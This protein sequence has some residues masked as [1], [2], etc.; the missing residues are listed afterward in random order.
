MMLSGRP[1]DV[2]MRIEPVDEITFDP[3][4]AMGIRRT[5]WEA[6]ADEAPVRSVRKLSPRPWQTLFIRAF[7]EDESHDGGAEACRSLMAFRNANVRADLR[8][9]GSPEQDHEGACREMI[10][11]EICG[12]LQWQGNFLTIAA[13][14]PGIPF[15]DEVD[16]LLLAHAWKVMRAGGAKGVR[17]AIV[18]PQL[19]M[20]METLFRTRD[21]TDLPRVMR[22]FPPASQ[23]RKYVPNPPAVPL[24]AL[25]SPETGHQSMQSADTA[26]PQEDELG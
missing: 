6:L 26:L 1:I 10:R 22:L 23:R 15:R 13:S 11:G 4:T 3:E 9:P 2:S 5:A 8:L 19:R 21:I 14:A 20:E 16:T 17:P 18:I 12:V 24:N 7:C 25:E